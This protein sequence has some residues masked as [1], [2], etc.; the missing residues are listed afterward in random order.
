MLV[1]AHKGGLIR[2]LERFS[3]TMLDPKATSSFALEI[4]Q[5]KPGSVY[6][7]IQ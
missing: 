6:Q 7:F 2:V 5:E 3:W 4:C 1:C